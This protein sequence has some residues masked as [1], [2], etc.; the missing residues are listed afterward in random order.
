V[1]ARG[2]MPVISVQGQNMVKL[3]SF[4]AVGGGELLGIWA[5]DAAREMKS[6]KLQARTGVGI[7]SKIKPE[8]PLA[9]AVPVAGEGAG[10][11][12]GPGDD[13]DLD[14]DADDDLDLD[15]DNDLDLDLDADGDLDLD[16]DLDADNDLDLDADDGDDLDDLLAGFGDDDEDDDDD[17]DADLAALLGDL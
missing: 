14:M 1:I 2:F 4:Q 13:L 9:Q 5:G 7:S 10:L 15:A 12:D 6:G 11:E 16:L 3:G 17:L 8:K